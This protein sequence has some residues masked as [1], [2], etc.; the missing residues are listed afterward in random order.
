MRPLLFAAAFE[1]LQFEPSASLRFRLP[2]RGAVVPIL[3]PTLG[4]SL[5]YGPDYESEVSGDGR[6]PSFFALGP[7]LGA[8]GGLDFSRPEKSF[9]FQLGLTG[10]VTPLFTIDDPENHR[11][12]V[13]GAMLDLSFRFR[14]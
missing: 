14:L 9:N 2:T 6:G 7:I 10:Y 5:H 8:Y 3:G 13:A 12:V 4:V 11:G 1:T